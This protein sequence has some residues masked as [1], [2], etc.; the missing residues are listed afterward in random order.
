MSYM[1]NFLKRAYYSKLVHGIVFPAVQA[2]RVLL[3]RSRYRRKLSCLRAKVQRGEKLRVIF[4]AD[5]PS[6]W[7]YQSIYEE[8]KNS[9]VFDPIVGIDLRGN[10]DSDLSVEDLKKQRTA[11]RSFY[12][13]LG[14]SCVWAYDIN[15]KQL[16]DAKELG[17]DLVFYQEPWMLVGCHRVIEVSKYALTAYVPYSV[18]WGTDPAFHWQYE[19]QRLIFANF[20]WSREQAEQE[21]PRSCFAKSGRAYCVGHT[22][23]DKYMGLNCKDKGDGVIYAPH[24]AFPYKDVKNITIFGTFEW[25]GRKMLEYAQRHPYVNWVWKPHPALRWQLEAKGF[26]TH[27]E[28]DQYFEAWENLGT[29]CYDGDYFDLFISSRAMITDCGSFLLEYAP[30]TNPIIRPL[31]ERFTPIPSETASKVFQSYYTVRN[32]AEMESCLD[33]VILGRDDYRR[34][35]RIAAVKNAKLIGN[36]AGKAVVD[37]LTRTVGS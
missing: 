27:D 26:M 12:E 37:I 10:H 30:T 16:V 22:S 11:I 5:D 33:R 2:G 20:V 24:F 18:E 17:A 21:C 32:W 8:M 14:C 31:A 19:F 25:N 34:A 36:L 6:K 3:C 29:A 23:F 15:T 1:I 7:K 35:E 13:R 9:D 28:V 4:L